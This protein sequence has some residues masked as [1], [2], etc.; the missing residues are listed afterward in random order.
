VGAH[1]FD[2]GRRWW[3]LASV[4]E[5]IRRVRAAADPEAGGELLTVA[6]L[7][8]EFLWL[9]LRETAGVQRQDFVERYGLTIEEAFAGVVQ[10]LASHGLLEVDPVRIR[11]SRRGMDMA[12]RVLA[13]FLP[14]LPEKRPALP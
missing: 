10:D 6:D 5:Y 4:P 11:L 14:D 12:N 13:E 1:S 3:N 7:R 2:A 8:A 9:G